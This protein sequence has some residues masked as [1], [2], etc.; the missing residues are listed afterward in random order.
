MQEFECLLPLASAQD[1]YRMH[2]TI[3]T[4]LHG[5]GP[6]RVLYAVA[7]AGEQAVLRVACEHEAT[8]QLQWPCRPVAPIEP[9]E[10]L[11][12]GFVMEANAHRAIGGG[13]AGSGQRGKRV[14]IAEPTQAL[15]WLERQLARA[16]AVLIDGHGHGLPSLKIR[17]KGHA[18]HFTRVMLSG[19]ARITD[20]ATFAAARAQGFGGGKAFGMGLM[21]LL[22]HT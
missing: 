3:A 22:P 10:D 11:E 9:A 8:P 17:R 7:P 1:R 16:G 6:G 4:A 21:V 19:K 12:L 2:Q 14:G 15:A 18:L 13:P 5:Q 20:P